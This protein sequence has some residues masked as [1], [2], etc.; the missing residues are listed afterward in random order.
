MLKMISKTRDF[1][2]KNEKSK[3]AIKS[4]IENNNEAEVAG[5]EIVDYVVWCKAKLKNE[6][7]YTEY[8]NFLNT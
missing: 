2:L 1:S 7:Y 8:I 3:E 4:F 5:N 6:K